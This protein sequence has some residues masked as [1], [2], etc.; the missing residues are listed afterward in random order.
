VPRALQVMIGLAT[1]AGVAALALR[2]PA[3]PVAAE[4]IAR[5]ASAA[6][7][8]ESARRAAPS[9]APPDAKP[10]RDFLGVFVAREATE[11][12]ALG[13]GR[14]ASIEVRIG[15]RVRAGQTVASLD[16]RAQELE[17]NV[18]RLQADEASAELE[19]AGS[20]TATAIDNDTRQRNLG[21]SGLATGAEQAAASAAR[22]VA[23][24]RAASARATLLR[25]RATVSRLVRSRDEMLVRAPFDGVVVA[26]YLDPGANV[27]PDR[28]ILRLV[29]SGEM[30]VRF[31]LPEERA[32]QVHIGTP[33]R[34]VA[35][36]TGG[37][38]TAIVR[39]LSSEVDVA[40][41]WFVVEADVAGV[42]ANTL[43]GASADVFL[44][45]K[46]SPAP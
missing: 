37:D 9:P 20:L 23:E 6:H 36:G 22:R 24:L 43:V 19:V 8:L 2:G 14:I 4:R 33:V 40:A 32:N 5:A 10:K 27:T 46:A 1:L 42:P 16:T 12:A 17:L 34:A 26:R 28:P 3:L 30:I 38:V 39:R 21:E 45:T 41:R 35:P 31:A 25:Q 13:P 15:D 44:L 29:R 11:V 7:P 18:A